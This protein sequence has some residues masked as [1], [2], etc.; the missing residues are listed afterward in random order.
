MVRFAAERPRDVVD[1]AFFSAV[2]AFADVLSPSRRGSRSSTLISGWMLYE[3]RRRVGDGLVIEDFGGGQDGR[4]WIKQDH[5]QEIIA[6]ITRDL[7]RGHRPKVSVEGL[8][9]AFDALVIE[10][11][12]QLSSLAGFGLSHEQPTETRRLRVRIL[13]AFASYL[14]LCHDEPGGT[15]QS[16]K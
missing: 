2:N 13:D 10:L 15:F 5:Q 6:T 8:A 3:V 14:S 9:N 7:S 4:V 12:R 11:R 1:K 16:C